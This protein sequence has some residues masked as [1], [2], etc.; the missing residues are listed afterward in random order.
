[1][2][3]SQILELFTCNDVAILFHKGYGEKSWWTDRKFAEDNMKKECSL[4]FENQME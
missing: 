3:K 4:A 2:R 1:M